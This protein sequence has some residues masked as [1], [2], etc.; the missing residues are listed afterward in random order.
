MDDMITIHLMV[1]RKLVDRCD[2]MLP[3]FRST[4]PGIRVGRPDLL[5][6]ALL[7]G[8]DSIV[9]DLNTK[10]GWE[11]EAKPPGRSPTDASQEPR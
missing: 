10:P 6:T 2:D 9:A 1:D 7:R 11:R 8:L 4:F 3:H 5:R